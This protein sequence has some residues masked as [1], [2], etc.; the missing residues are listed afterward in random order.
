MNG[1]ILKWILVAWAFL[2]I[3]LFPG[4]H[5]RTISLE[6]QKSETRKTMD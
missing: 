4:V 1:G 6:V 2:P 3:S 5:E